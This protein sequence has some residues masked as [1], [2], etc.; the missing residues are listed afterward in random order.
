MT[1]RLTYSVAEA[2]KVLGVS[3]AMAYAAV[4]SGQLPSVRLGTRILIPKAAVS[5]LLGERSGL[6]RDFLSAVDVQPVAGENGPGSP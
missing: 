3:K 1:A 2:A 6:E 4:H 5:Q